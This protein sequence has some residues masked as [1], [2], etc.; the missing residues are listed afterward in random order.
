M[1]NILNQKVGNQKSVHVLYVKTIMKSMRKNKL[2]GAY[3]YTK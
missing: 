3:S 1:A 2:H